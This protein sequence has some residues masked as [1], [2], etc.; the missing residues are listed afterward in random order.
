MGIIVFTISTFL[1]S[2]QWFFLMKSL[3]INVKLKSVVSYYYTGL[4]FNNFLLSFIG[5]DLFRIY[6]ASKATGKNSESISTVFLD[7]L[8]GFTVLSSFAFI[9]VLF[10][11]EVLKSRIVMTFIIGFFTI[12]IFLLLFFY[13]KKFA[14]KFESFGQRILPG[15]IGEKLREIYRGINYFRYRKKLILQLFLLSIFIQVLRVSVHYFTAKSLS[16]EI[17][18]LYFLIFIP[19]I[20]IVI[21]LPSIGGLG[22]REHSAALLF[23][24]IGTIP[25]KSSSIVFLAYLI[26]IIASLPGGLSFVFRNHKK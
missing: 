6:D 18:F 8:I 15:K 7:R 24:S 26:G 3:R 21:L 11:M 25:V 19:V 12:F 13:F 5:G 17:N 16:L 1:G 2:I 10:S 23:G 4:F 20:S 22:I 14:K 9:G